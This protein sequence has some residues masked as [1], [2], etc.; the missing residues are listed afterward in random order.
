MKCFAN[1]IQPVIYGSSILIPKLMQI[2]IFFKIKPLH[3]FQILIEKEVWDRN[4]PVTLKTVYVSY[5]ES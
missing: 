1:F 3:F 2:V 4:F 5:E